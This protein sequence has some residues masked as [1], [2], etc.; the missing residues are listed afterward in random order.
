MRSIIEFLVTLAT[1]TSAGCSTSPDDK[2]GKKGGSREQAPDTHVADARPPDID[3]N[4]SECETASDCA[5]GSDCCFCEAVPRGVVVGCPA[6]CLTARCDVLGI[7]EQD[8]LCLGGRC[9]LNR[10]CDSKKATC[11]ASAPV[12][13][14]SVYLPDSVPMIEHGCWGDCLESSEC[15]DLPGVRD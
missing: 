14:A 9:V 7:T 5:L 13:P 4:T 1:L 2:V 6:D 10:E 3:A 11:D 15:A 12:C 8:I